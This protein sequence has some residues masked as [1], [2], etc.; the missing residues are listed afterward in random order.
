MTTV[1]VTLDPETRALYDEL[2]RLSRE[3][4]ARH[5][6]AQRNANHAQVR[7]SLDLLTRHSIISCSIRPLLMHSPRLLD[8]ANLPCIR[9]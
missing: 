8:C 9:R 5:I 4:F 6:N 7:A 1:K 2:E 3:H